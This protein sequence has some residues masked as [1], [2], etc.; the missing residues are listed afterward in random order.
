MSLEHEDAKKDKKCVWKELV[1]GAIY[2]CYESDCRE[3]LILATSVTALAKF[4]FCPFCGREIEVM[5]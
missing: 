4:N 2:M 3:R 5:K 1:C